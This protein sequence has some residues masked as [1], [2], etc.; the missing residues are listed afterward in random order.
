MTATKVAQS[1]FI[2]QFLAPSLFSNTACS[3]EL[4]LYHVCPSGQVQFLEVHSRL[5]KFWGP[6]VENHTRLP[7]CAVA[8]DNTKMLPPRPCLTPCLPA[9]SFYFRQLEH[10][11]STCGSLSLWGSHIRY[12]EYQMFTLWSITAQN[13][14]Y[15][16]LTK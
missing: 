1:F 3:P 14:S 6:P 12:P 2:S 8:A 7:S 15:E 16:V 9:K 10:S 5:R 4:K 11:R 13:Y